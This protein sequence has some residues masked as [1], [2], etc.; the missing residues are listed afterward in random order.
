[1][2]GARLFSFTS[3]AILLFLCYYMATTE[4]STMPGTWCVLYG[5]AQ[6]YVYRNVLWESAWAQC[7]SHFILFIEMELML[8]WCLIV[9]FAR[10]FFSCEEKWSGKYKFGFPFVISL[11]LLDVTPGDVGV[12][13][14]NEEGNNMNRFVFQFLT[15][16]EGNLK[17]VIYLNGPEYTRNRNNEKTQI[18]KPKHKRVRGVSE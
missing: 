5:C 6:W 8:L 3:S 16:L 4:F 11:K 1:M 14:C 2:H 10:F 18:V 17:S 9:M 7:F 12:V 13:G 15:T